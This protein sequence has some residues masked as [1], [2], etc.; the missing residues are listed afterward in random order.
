MSVF[1]ANFQGELLAASSSLASAQSQNQSLQQQMLVVSGDARSSAAAAA[2]AAAAL[3]AR[4]ARIEKLEKALEE[5]Q[6]AHA[7][8]LRRMSDEQYVPAAV[9]FFWCP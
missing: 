5:Q 9:V 8:E 2:T 6:A 4:E 7:M 3:A 1:D